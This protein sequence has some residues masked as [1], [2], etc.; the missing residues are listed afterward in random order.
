MVTA[1]RARE[2]TSTFRQQ[3]EYAP[4][5]KLG[6]ILDA[7]TELADNG[8]NSLFIAPT[9]A[10]PVLDTLAGLGYTITHREKYIEIA[11]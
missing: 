9:T 11:W 1:Q 8:F 2:Q 5:P 3:F 10:M 7:I 6:T 4:S